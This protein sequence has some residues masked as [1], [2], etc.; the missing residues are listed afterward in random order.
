MEHILRTFQNLLAQV[1]GWT[2]EK[3]DAEVERIEG[4]SQCEYL[5]DLLMGVFLAY[6]RAFAVLQ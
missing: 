3:V 4:S 2:S 6:I 1:P 5:D